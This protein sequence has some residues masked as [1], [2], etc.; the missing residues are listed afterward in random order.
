MAV[1]TGPRRRLDPDAR[2]RQLIE[3]GL[4]LLSRAPREQVAIDRIAEE[5]GVS[6]GLLFHYFPTKRD[7]HVAV[8]TAA[9]ERLVRVTEPDPGLPAPER[10]RRSLE[11]YV[12]YVIENRELYVSLVRGA[13]GAD[14]ELQRVFDRTRGHIVERIVANLNITGAAPLLR[15]A[16]R[17]W[18]ALVEE[19]TLDALRGGDVAHDDLVGLQQRALAS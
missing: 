10:L 18:L 19:T 17:G 2:R 5:A 8:V 4:R 13:A 7:F 15:T 11:A 6:R 1:S 12:R 9:A 16:L 14:E 3:L